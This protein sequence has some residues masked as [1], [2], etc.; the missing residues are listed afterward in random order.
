[1]L[2]ASVVR[3]ED[4]ATWTAVVFTMAMV[5]VSGTFFEIPE[6]SVIEIISRISINTY[7][8]NAFKTLIIEG[9]SLADL[10][11]ELGIIAG[12]AVVALGISRVLFRVVPGGK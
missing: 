2:I 6:G 9:G 10:G 11:F 12:I 3:S 8:N 1:M 7:A 5:M 4:A